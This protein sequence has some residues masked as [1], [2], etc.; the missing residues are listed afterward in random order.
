MGDALKLKLREKIAEAFNDPLLRKTNEIKGLSIYKVSVKNML[1]ASQPHYIVAIVPRD[2]TPMF[3]VKRL[4]KLNW[5]S[6]QT[7]QVPKNE[8]DDDLE[9]CPNCEIPS[10]HSSDVFLN[11][12]ITKISQT[13]DQVQ[14]LSKT[15]PCSITLLPSGVNKVARF[16]E[17]S[18][19][20]KAMIYFNTIITIN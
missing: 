6:F 13:E 8:K 19:F 7:R 17:N 5:V 3:E 20:Y 1:I 4:S 11:D 2:M 10:H 9:N 15:L 14:Y 18:N 16:Q 12:T